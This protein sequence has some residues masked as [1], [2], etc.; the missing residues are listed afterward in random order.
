MFVLINIKPNINGMFE[1]EILKRPKLH[2]VEAAL[3]KK[4]SDRVLI[5][6]VS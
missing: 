5:G 1:S 4:Y 3:K 2:P 6:R